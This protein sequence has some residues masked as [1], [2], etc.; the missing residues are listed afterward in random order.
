MMWVMPWINR[1]GSM[2]SLNFRPCEAIMRTWGSSLETWEILL[3]T[4]SCSWEDTRKFE[5]HM[6]TKPTLLWVTTQILSPTHLT[7]RA[8]MG[9][10][11]DHW[12]L[13]ITRLLL[14]S[15]FIP[16]LR[17]Y[18]LILQDYELINSHFWIPKLSTCS[19]LKTPRGFSD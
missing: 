7:L 14:K 17:Y 3:G 15:H 5:M 10:W 19:S 13:I 11:E 2:T 18:V 6:A 16:S 12:P 9:T 1:F 8:S 4:Q